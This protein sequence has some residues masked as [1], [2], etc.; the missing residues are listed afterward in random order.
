M[1]LLR[2]GLLIPE[3]REG[4]GSFTFWPHEWFW[5]GFEHVDPVKEANAQSKRLE[6]HTTTL[7]DEYAKQGKDWE[8]QLRQRAR[9]IDMMDEL[10]LAQPQSLSAMSDDDFVDEIIDRIEDN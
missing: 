10:G 3:F 9:E 8:V 2:F 5:D 7:A 6:N 1:V 4:V